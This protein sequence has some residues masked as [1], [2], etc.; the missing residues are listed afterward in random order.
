[1]LGVG[2]IMVWENKET[3]TSSIYHLDHPPICSRKV[4]AVLLVDRRGRKFSNMDLVES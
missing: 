1:L 4:V 3:T 2:D